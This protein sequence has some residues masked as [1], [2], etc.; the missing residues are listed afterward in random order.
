MWLFLELCIADQ[1]RYLDVLQRLTDPSRNDRI[2]DFACGLGQDLRKLAFDGVDPKK[3]YGVDLSQ[4]L[5]DTGFD[6]FR[7]RTIDMTFATGDIWA[8]DPLEKLPIGEKTFDIVHVSAFFHVS[9]FDQQ[10][11]IAKSLAMFLCEKANTLIFGWTT[12]TVKAGE[13]VMGKKGEGRA[14]THNVESFQNLWEEVGK[15]TQTKWH[16]E[17]VLQKAPEIFDRIAN[18]HTWG[19]GFPERMFLKF[20]VQKA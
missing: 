18:T 8:N 12:G 6:L 9:S 14:Y 3:L 17:A 11:Q 4:G 5:I 19:Q 20:S 7:D 1:P 10:I 2:L 16:V 13:Y 15:Q